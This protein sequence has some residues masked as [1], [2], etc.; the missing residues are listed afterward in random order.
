MGLSDTDVWKDNF[1]RN[2]YCEYIT[3]H[4][5]L[6]T[7]VY[8]LLYGDDSFILHILRQLLRG[9]KDHIVRRYFFAL[10]TVYIR[11]ISAKRKIWRECL[12]I[13][14]VGM[15]YGAIY[16]A[17]W[18]YSFPSNAEKWLWQACTF[19]IAFAVSGPCV[20]GVILFYHGTNMQPGVRDYMAIIHR[21]INMQLRESLAN[22]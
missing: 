20:P 12:I 4:S 2:R 14:G 7:L 6:G 10:D 1:F 8:K 11:M 21:R 5:R 19:V 17:T 22:G 15:V 16:V 9:R 18:N 3:P 13:C